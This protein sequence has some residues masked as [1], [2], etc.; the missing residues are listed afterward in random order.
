MNIKYPAPATYPKYETLLVDMVE[1][2]IMKVTLNRPKA[3]NALSHQ[4][5]GELTDLCERLKDDF[6]N[7]EGYQSE[8]TDGYLAAAMEALTVEEANRN[9]QLVQWDGVTGTSMRGECPWVWIVN[10]DHVTFVRDGLSIGQQP[11]H[12]HGH[13]LPLIQNLQDWAWEA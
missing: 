13:G 5:V 11:I 7:A 10:L 4:L 6:Y 1:P 9:W 3:Y 8:V 12:S 2:N